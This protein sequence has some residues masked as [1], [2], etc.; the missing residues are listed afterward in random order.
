MKIFNNKIVFGVVIIF[1]FIGYVAPV[2]AQNLTGVETVS[3]PDLALTVSN[4][5]QDYPSK[6][7]TVELKIASK[8]N[9]SK[10]GVEWRYPK[11]LLNVEGPDTDYVSVSANQTT[12]VKKNFYPAPGSVYEKAVEGTRTASISV[13]VN[14]FLAERNYLSTTSFDLMFN[15][16]MELMPINQEYQ[17]VK[18]T[19]ITLNWTWKIFIV[20][21]VVGIIVFGIKKFI[22]Y[23]NSDDRE[24]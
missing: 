14:A 20:V 15:S 19:K 2:F 9:S 10:V 21:A 12:I 16:L 17:I 1:F 3:D 5:R 22:N 18:Y 6:I 7:F 23:I 4:T 13:K 24:K 11:N 8:I